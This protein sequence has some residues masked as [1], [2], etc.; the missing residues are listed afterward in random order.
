MPSSFLLVLLVAASTSSIAAQ[1]DSARPAT[2]RAAG[3]DSAAPAGSA[4]R[5]G[6]GVDTDADTVPR[7]SISR[8]AQSR[9]RA[10]AI[11]HYQLGAGSGRND[12]YQ[13]TRLRAGVA[14]AGPYVSAEVSGRHALSHDRDLVGGA[15]ASDVDRWDLETASVT[16]RCCGGGGAGAPL[17]A[18][19]GRQ[20]IAVGAER[21]VGVSDWSNARRAFDA[22][23]AA[24]TAGTMSVDLFA[25]RPVVVRAG[26][27]NHGDSLTALLGAVA[28]P[29]DGRWQLYALGY[30]RASTGAGHRRTTLGSRL[31]RDTRAGAIGYDVE[32]AWQTG[33]QAGQRVAAWFLA[34]ETSVAL[35]GSWSPVVTLGVD[36]ASGDHD[37]ADGVTQTFHVPFASSH[38]HGGAADVV[39]RPNGFQP[40]L[41]VAVSPLRRLQLRAAAHHF[42]RLRATDAAYAKD[43]SAL[44][45]AAAGSRTVG[46]ELDLMA[47][48]RV[49]PWMRLQGGYGHFAPGA[50]LRGASQ[51]A[52]KLDW[53][54][55]AT[56]FDF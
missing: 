19:V 26:D 49:V 44:R 14:L 56:T 39:G 10:E 51:P 48:F 5:N 23:S 35:A 6:A 46:N 55:L 36:A 15:R 11:S 4:R 43:G 25:G 21:L 32:G 45:P 27:A 33:R 37:A 50:F 30:H 31:H 12:S 3:A 29:A 22:V 52:T 17:S 2:P 41:A 16:L 20:T 1:P 42:G 13:A 8:F 28:G 54:F 40:R 47:T 24:L 34:V 38:S 18:R 9:A 53:A 7:W